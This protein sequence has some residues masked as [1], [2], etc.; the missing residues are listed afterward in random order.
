MNVL[1]VQIGVMLMQIATT[2][3]GVTPA[4]ATVDT[5]AMGFLATVSSPISNH[6]RYC[7]SQ[8]DILCTN[9]QTLS[10]STT[11]EVVSTL[12]TTWM[13]VTHVPAI[14]DTCLLMM[15]KHVKVGIY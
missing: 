3:K 12:A 1:E 10:A 5:Q 2:L 7:Y 11:M 4:L 9:I 8:A 13:G 14:M 6:N 15:D